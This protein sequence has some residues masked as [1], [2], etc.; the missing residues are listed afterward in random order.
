MIRIPMVRTPMVR[1]LVDRTLLGRTLVGRTL[2][3]RTLALVVLM[4]VTSCVTTMS[5]PPLASA[6][7]VSDFDTYRIH[8]VGLMPP[9]GLRLT[10]QQSEH[11]QAAFMAEFSAATDFEIVR[12]TARDLEAIPR[13]EAH[14]RGR[15]SPRTVSEISRRYHLDALLV[16]TVTDLQTYPPQRLGVQVDL[17]SS[18]TGQ[19]LWESSVQLDAT[20]E[21]VRRSIEVWA[22][23]HLGDVSDNTWELTLISPSRFA[24]FAAY[25]MASLI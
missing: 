19:S 20:Q 5:V 15:Y 10:L 13:M 18:E 14:L 16:P 11:L 8:R 25:Q 6:R 24:R 7:M 9:A 21:R 1:T 4:G 2:V 17:L 12:L 22:D 3:V 23:T